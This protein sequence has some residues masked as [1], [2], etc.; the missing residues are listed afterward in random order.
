MKGNLGDV[1]VWISCAILTLLWQ[2]SSQQD[3]RPPQLA[4]HYPIQSVQGGGVGARAQQTPS[5]LQEQVCWMPGP[6]LSFHSPFGTPTIRI[7]VF[8]FLQKQFYVTLRPWQSFAH[9][10]WG[11]KDFTA[12]SDAAGAVPIGMGTHRD[13]AGETRALL[14]LREGESV[15]QLYFSDGFLKG[16]QLAQ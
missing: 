14:A 2:K 10:R 4:L 3:E 1:L 12:C 16:A 7:C 11:L 6:T 5:C 9:R 15:L 8:E 13:G